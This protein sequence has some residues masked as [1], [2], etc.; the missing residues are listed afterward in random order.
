MAE[1][2]RNITDAGIGSTIRIAKKNDKRI[3]TL[4]DYRFAT[5]SNSFYLYIEF[6]DGKIE[7]FWRPKDV[8]II[9]KSPLPCTGFVGNWNIL[10]TLYSP[11]NLIGTIT[12]RYQLSEDMNLMQRIGYQF[13]LNDQLHEGLFPLFRIAFEKL[14]EKYNN[15]D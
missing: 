9:N 1:T 3:G 11:E 13:K 12:Y 14:M 5:H 6:E 8:V 2:I 4:L 7:E 15:I 10:K